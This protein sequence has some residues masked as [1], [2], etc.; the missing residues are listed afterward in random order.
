MLLIVSNSLQNDSSSLQ[1]SAEEEEV[2]SDSRDFKAFPIA[3]PLNSSRAFSYQHHICQCR[4]STASW[5]HRVERSHQ[6]AALVKATGTE[7]VGGCW[8]AAVP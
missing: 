7:S 2:L 4:L 5:R 8:F 1:R 3:L 6:K